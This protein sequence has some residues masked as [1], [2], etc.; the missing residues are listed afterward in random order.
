MAGGTGD[1][2]ARILKRHE[3]ARVDCLD[4]NPAML[5]EGQ[6]RFAGQ[7][8]GRL[9]FLA[10]N[11]ESL[12]LPSG[13]YDGYS[14][15][16]ASAMCRAF[17]LALAEAYRVLRFGGRFLCLEFSHVTMPGLDSLYE[18][19]SFHVIPRMGGLVT[20]DQDSYRYLVES[21]RRFPKRKRSAR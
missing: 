3:G 15:A 19:Y 2:A 1:I 12:P 13:A 6:R 20:G 7:F 18:A 10:G 17:P 8:D 16:F 14:I 21:I 5:E 11:A 4:I 9:R